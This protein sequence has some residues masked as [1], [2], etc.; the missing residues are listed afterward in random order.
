MRRGRRDDG[1]RRRSAR[2]RP[3][4]RRSRRA[5]WPAPAAP[6]AP[7]RVSP[8]SSRR[9][10]ASAPVIA[11]GAALRA[12]PAD[13]VAEQ[14]QPDAGDRA[15]RRRPAARR[16]AATSRTARPRRR[17]G[18]SRRRAPSAGMSSMRANSSIPSTLNAPTIRAGPATGGKPASIVVAHRLP[19]AQVRRDE[20]L[21]APAVAG[22]ERLERG[23]GVGEV[24]RE[25]G[26]A[27]AGQ[28]VDHRQ[29]GLDPAQAVALELH[30]GEDR[31]GDADGMH[32]RED[33]VA[34]AG[35]REL[36]G[37]RR[38]AE[39]GGPLDA[40]HRAPAARERHRGRSGRWAR[41]RRR[42][43]RSGRAM[44]LRRSAA[45]SAASMLDSGRSSPQNACW[46]LRPGGAVGLLER[47]R[48]VVPGSRGAQVGLA[49][50][51]VGE[52]PVARRGP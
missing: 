8:P 48:Q 17:R 27:A 49:V 43:R 16:R 25:R 45:R 5:G 6:A 15:A 52:Q 23:D 41:R 31:R 32:G 33:V 28:R 35:Q 22:R 7:A 40:Q 21:P 30:L 24:A 46:A 9:R 10:P 19:V 3:A 20:R 51:L 39:R 26:A 2:R 34:K 13:G 42:R 37:L 12:R 4:R 18:R 1:A 36:G 44:P 29:L 50:E 38:A 11:P 14:V 47:H